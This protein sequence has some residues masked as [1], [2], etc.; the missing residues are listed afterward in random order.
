MEQY[1]GN[2]EGGTR[3]QSTNIDLSNIDEFWSLFPAGARAKY[4][5]AKLAYDPKGVFPTLPDKLL[6]KTAGA[7]KANVYRSIAIQS[8]PTG[9]FIDV[10]GGHKDDGATVGMWSSDGN[11]VLW[12]IDNS[13]D[14]TATI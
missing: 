4:G 14:G 12:L 8:P 11:T 3:L 1:F 6:S 7:S 10:F 9:R 5:A 13:T 2:V